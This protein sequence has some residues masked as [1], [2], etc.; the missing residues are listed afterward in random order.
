LRRRSSRLMLRAAL[1]Y[2]A[3]SDRRD[4]DRVDMPGLVSFSPLYGDQACAQITGPLAKQ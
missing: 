1:R 3:D 2:F 4:V